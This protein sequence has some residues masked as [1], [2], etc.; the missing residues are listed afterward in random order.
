MRKSEK[1]KQPDSTSSKSDHSIVIIKGDD[2]MYF[3][4][5]HNLEKYQYN[6][7][8]R[9]PCYITPPLL[10]INELKKNAN[11]NIITKDNNPTNRK[12]E[13]KLFKEHFESIILLYS[14]IIYYIYYYK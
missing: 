11:I 3:Q 9:R 12:Y 8:E 6:Y 1:N 10:D 13:L 7:L 5:N 2:Q 14:I 4:S